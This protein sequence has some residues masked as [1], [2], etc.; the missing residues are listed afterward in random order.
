M[1]YNLTQY[2]RNQFPNE[3]FYPVEKYK[4]SSQSTIPDRINIIRDTGGIEQPW[5]RYS[6]P[7]LQILSRDSS[8]AAARKLAY[9]IYD[10]LQ[11][12]QFGLILPAITVGS[13]TYPAKQ[14]AQISAIQQPFKLG[15]D[16]NGRTE[17]A[18]N[19]KIILERGG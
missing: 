13:T 17:Y 14:I 15:T 11:S 3:V 8:P 12:H 6:Q 9:D 16:D 18:T 5:T 4:T 7:T 10:H 1:T 2:L 19:Y